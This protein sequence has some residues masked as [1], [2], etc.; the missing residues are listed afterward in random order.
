MRGL[1]IIAACI[2]SLA[3]AWSFPCVQAPQEREDRFAALDSMMVQYLSAIQGS[4]PEDKMRESD[5]MIGAAADT[6]V[7]RHVALKLFDHYKEAPV[8]GDEAV[9]IHI[10]DRW[11]ASGDIKMRS[12]FDEMDAKLFADFNRNSLIGMKAP[13]ISL[14]KPCGGRMTIP[15]EGSCVILWFHDTSCG[16]CKLEAKVLP[17]VLEKADFPIVF[18]AVYAGQSKKEW[19]IFRRNFRLE[20]KRI[21]LVHLWDPEIESDYL[22]LYGVISTPKLYMTA[23]D[24]RII[25]RRLEPESLA[26][27]LPIAARIA[28]HD[29]D[30]FKIR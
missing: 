14:R 15:Q 12:E 2:L 7:R 24:G 27:L 4:G 3:R 22:S 13:V 30:N 25:G 18:Y 11:F 26:R 20:N 8:M 21:K 9:A 19:R 10:Y 16:K 17:S 29:N 1:A 6:A 5:F 23:P 28:E